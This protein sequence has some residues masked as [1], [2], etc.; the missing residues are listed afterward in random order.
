MHGTTLYI[1]KLSTRYFPYIEER[2]K[3]NGI[4]DDFKYVCVAESALQQSAASPVGAASYWQFMKESGQHYG[5]EVNDNVDERYNLKKATEAACLYYKDAYN[6]FGSWTA[7]AAS[8]NCGITGYA[9]QVEFQ[10]GRTFYD[11]AF[12]EET[13]R[14]VFR[15]VAIKYL[16]MYAKSYGFMLSGADTY[17]PMR[18]RIVTV[19]KT[20]INLSDFAKENGSSYKLLK[21]LNPWLR[22]HTLPVKPGKTYQIELPEERE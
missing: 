1:L 22:S 4:P 11:M 16:M 15:I 3:A 14:Y 8:Y 5:L 13:N 10:G 2:L 18:T 9:N 12:P 20:I 17:K 19:D 7:C 6:K 21:L